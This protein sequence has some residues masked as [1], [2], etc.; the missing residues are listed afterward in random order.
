MN[1]GNHN[2]IMIYFWSFP[3]SKNISMFPLYCTWTT[4]E[5]NK[6]IEL[7]KEGLKLETYES[8]C[9]EKRLHGFRL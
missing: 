9:W 6:I 4:I 7:G 2:Y 5:K 3:N 1:V 8:V